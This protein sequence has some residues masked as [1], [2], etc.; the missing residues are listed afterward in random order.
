MEAAPPQVYT[1]INMSGDFIAFWQV[2][3]NNIS[4]FHP[5]NP[6]GKSYTKD[7][8]QWRQAREDYN[9][10]EHDFSSYD[11]IINAAWHCLGQ[12]GNIIDKSKVKLSALEVG[13]YFPRIWRGSYD[14]GL[15]S[16][17][18][19]IDA[20][21]IYGYKHT[22]ATVASSSL[23]N[24]LV[25]IFSYVEPSVEN[26]GAFGHKIRELIILTC[27]EIES[28]WR[29][30][31]LENGYKP[32]SSFTT[33]D[34]FHTKEALR[35]EQW[36][37]SLTEYPDLN[38]FS[39]FSDWESSFPTK[40][41]I[42]YDVYNAIKHNRE[43]CFHQATMEHLLNAVAAL[44][45]MQAA[46]WGPELYSFFH[47]NVPSPFQI[48]SYPTYEHFEMYIPSPSD[49]TSFAAKMYFQK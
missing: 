21:K 36:R 19:G 48:N 27:T 30:I 1:T 18:S 34:F 20:R 49:G 10:R 7:L 35:L 31:L 17:Y 43:A 8:S 29:A 2:D 42:W 26:F 11:E 22:Q 16:G 46:Q 45:I 6:W 33:A 12:H 28:A 4:F 3:E 13:K 47:G 44:F 15:L 23:F 25:D 14:S 38:S 39:P 40:S 41:L 37:V 9:K 32:K 24:Y 5:N